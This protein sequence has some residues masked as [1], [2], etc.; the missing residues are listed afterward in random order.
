MFFD[1]RTEFWWI[2]PYVSKGLWRGQLLFA[3]TH[4]EICIRKMLLQMLKWY[5]G[6]LHAALTGQRRQ[7]RR[8]PRKDLLPA[9]ALERL[10]R[11]LRRHAREDDIWRALFKA[12]ELFTGSHQA[13]PPKR[14]ALRSTDEYDRRVTSLPALTHDLPRDAKRSTLRD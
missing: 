6:A 1:C 7:V 3:Q 4:M 9:D 10:P 8:Q 5:A 2:A 13:A 12:G 11:D 14:S